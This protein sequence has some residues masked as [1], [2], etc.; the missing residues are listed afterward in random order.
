MM[1]LVKAP[2]VSQST[3]DFAPSHTV[4]ETSF[5][6]LGLF[7]LGSLITTRERVIR[8]RF[9]I[10]GRVITDDVEIDF[11]AAVVYLPVLDTGDNL[12]LIKNTY[13]LEYG[14]MVYTMQGVF[15]LYNIWGNVWRCNCDH[16]TAER[17]T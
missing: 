5:N 15:P 17:K 1:K 12:N 9:S 2:S 11:E 3:L 8:P 4:L 13:E 16:F 10:P 6:P 7:G 14:G